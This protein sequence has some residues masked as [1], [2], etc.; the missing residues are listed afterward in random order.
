[1]IEIVRWI[2]IFLIAAG[3]FFVMKQD[4]MKQVFS[5][6]KEGNRLYGFAGVRLVLGIFFMI[7]AHQARISLIIVLFG[8]FCFLSSILIFVIGVER[9]REY[10]KGI[11][12]KPSRTLRLLALLPIIMGTVILYSV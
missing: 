12:G 10:V 9:A 2:G 7:A 3:V 4:V 8:V 6:L 5:F 11:E 1:M